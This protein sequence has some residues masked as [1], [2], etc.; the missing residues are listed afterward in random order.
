MYV[1]YVAPPTK[2]ESFTVAFNEVDSDKKT[3]KKVPDF[4]KVVFDILRKRLGLHDEVALGDL[5]NM[6]YISTNMDKNKENFQYCQ[7][8]SGYERNEVYAFKISCESPH[9]D[10][11]YTIK[12]IL[13]KPILSFRV[14]INV[15]MIMDF[16]HSIQ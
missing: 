10:G 3:Y 4:H 8:F 12:W 2:T 16:K 13:F 6:R 7:V 9:Y 11:I 14:L 15:H 1:K 5:E